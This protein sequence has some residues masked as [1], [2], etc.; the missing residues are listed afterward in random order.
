MEIVKEMDLLVESYRPG[1]ME[2]LRLGPT[3]IHSINPTLKYVRL[4]GYSQACTKAG[5]DITYLAESGL[6]QKFRPSS[7][8]EPRMPGNFVADYCAGSLATFC[9]VLRV[10]HSPRSRECVVIDSSM[11]HN[12]AYFG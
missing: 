12:S 1:V 10:L 9:L 11:T 7:D 6:L 4:S 8:N 5:H 2:R 3:D